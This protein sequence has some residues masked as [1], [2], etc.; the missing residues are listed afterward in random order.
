MTD[1]PV[2]ANADDW[3]YNSIG[4]TITGTNLLYAAYNNTLFPSMISQAYIK[5]DTSAIPA[6]DV[7]SSATLYYYMDSYV[8]SRGVT[9]SFN[10]QMDT[11]GS[12]GS[13]TQIDIST[14]SAAGW[15]SI[16]LTPT[17]L[18][19]INKSGYT[20]FRVTVGN[21]GTA[22][23]RDFRIR[24]REHTFGLFKAYMS[25]T[26]APPANGQVISICNS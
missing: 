12:G 25:I 9:R 6:G 17:E 20:W 5:I 13:Y 10:T 24:A 21:P 14:Y 23:S 4:G 22:K 3:Y 26:H 8:A 15:H 19:Y 7:I 11:T 2:V 1:Y 18:G 16:V